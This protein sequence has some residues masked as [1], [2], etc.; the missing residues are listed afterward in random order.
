MTYF[1][2]HT[3]R[4]RYDWLANLLLKSWLIGADAQT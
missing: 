1:G 3:R 2:A 4:W